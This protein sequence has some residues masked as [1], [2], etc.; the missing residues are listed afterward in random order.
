MPL[1]LSPS[2]RNWLLRSRPFLVF[3]P[4]IATALLAAAASGRITPTAGIAYFLAVLLLWTLVE[5]LL[6]AAMHVKPRTPG[7]ARFQ[8]MAHL[9][10]HRHPEDLEHS[11]VKLGGSVPLA[12]VF[13]GLILLVLRDLPA[14]AICHAGLLSGYVFYEYVHLA[15]HAGSRPAWL[16]PLL[17]YHVRH[18]FQDQQR[19]FGVTSPLWDLIFGTLPRSKKD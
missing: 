16:R 12:A 1:A 6:H 4:V 9:R 14:A 17:K 19:T 10:H 13:F 15:S 5:W 2:R 18:H 11:V 3:P 7:M 8:D